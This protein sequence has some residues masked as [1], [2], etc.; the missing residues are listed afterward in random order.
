MALAWLFEDERTEASERVF[1]RVGDEGAVV[2]GLWW[3]EVANV[4]H[5]AVRRGRCTASVADAALLRARGLPL[6]TDGLT[7]TKAWGESLLLARS[8]GLTI[9]DA[10]YLELAIR[11]A[12]PLATADKALMAAA[13]RR[14]VT[15]L[16][17]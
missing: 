6:D 12:L 8:E 13:R 4:L 10:C 14:G 1:E 15:V 9:Y 17:P 7:A 11:R 5:I 16:A 2:P 3:L